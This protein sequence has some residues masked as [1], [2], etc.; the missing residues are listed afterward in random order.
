MNVVDARPNQRACYECGDPNHLRN[1]LFSLRWNKNWT[2]LGIASFGMASIL[3]AWWWE[4]KVRGRAYYASMNTAEVPRTLIV[5]RIADGKKVKVDRIIRGCKLELG[6]SLFTIDLI[7]L[8]HEIPLVDDEILRVHG[9][10]VEEST[11]ALK[12]AKVDEPTI[13]D[14]FV[15]LQDKGFIRPSH[16]PWGAP[17]LFL[18][19]K[20]GSMHMCIDYRKLNK[21][22]MKNRYPLLRIDDL[23]NQLQGARYFSKI[24]LRSGYHQLRVPEDDIPKTAFRIRTKEDHMITKINVGGVDK[25]MLIRKLS[26]CDFGYQ[27]DRSFSWSRVLSLP[28]GVVDFIVY[29]DASN[30]GLGCV[31]MQRDKGRHYLYGTKSVIYT[32]HK[33]LQHIFDQKDLNMHQRR[34]IELFSDYECVDFANRSWNK[35]R[36]VH[37]LVR[38]KCSKVKAEHQRPSGLLQQPE[39]PEWKWDKITIDFITKLPRS[40]NGHDTIWVIVDRLTKLAHF[41]AIREDYSTKRLARIYIDE[42]VARHGV[43]MSIISDKD[44]WFTSPCWQTVQKALGTRLDMSMAY[45]PQTDGQSE[46]TIQTL[47]DMLRACVIDFSG[48]WDVHVPLAKFSYNNS[49]HSSIRCALL[50]IVWLK[51]NVVACLLGCDGCRIRKGVIRFGKRVSCARYVGSFKILEK[52]RSVAYRLRLPEELSG[53]H[54]TFHV[55]NLKKCLVD[56]SLHVTL[57][58]IKVDKTLRFVK[59]PV[60]SMDREIKSLKCS[61]IS[62]VKVRWNSKRGPEFTWERKDYMKSKYPQLFVEQ[63]DES[64]S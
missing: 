24:D 13:S 21:L 59:E 29:Y 43:P 46:R 3:G 30:Q 22:T 19:K 28:D 57:D 32:D 27:E 7:P 18:K 50:S 10:R 40:K 11:K 1:V 55:S 42:I 61:K 16:S 58:E 23:F 17:M 35:E 33:S 45:H 15:E 56:A 39:I 12:K 48:S 64:A 49:Y 4:F 63:I 41:L 14:I 2:H 8:G 6:S 31:L 44:G 26:T 34:W 47:E 36:L 54:D 53:V 51:E 5:V 25:E 62:L 20:D 60:E 37:M 9:E 52:S 38:F